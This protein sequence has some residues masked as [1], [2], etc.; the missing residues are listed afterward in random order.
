MPCTQSHFSRRII[1]VGGPERSSCSWNAKHQGHS[2]HRH[3]VQCWP[4]IGEQNS[5][6][7]RSPRPEQSVASGAETIVL[8]T[9]R[10]SAASAACSVLSSVAEPS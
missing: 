2:A 4:L 5:S 3:E 7:E 1:V 9:L 6:H 8:A 10:I